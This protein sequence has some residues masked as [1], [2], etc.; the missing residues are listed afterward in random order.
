MDLLRLGRA[1]QTL[2]SD[3]RLEMFSRIC[4]GRATWKTISKLPTPSLNLAILRH[5]G[6]VE[7]VVGIVTTWRLTE[8]GHRVE[9]V[10]A[11]IEEDNT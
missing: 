2:H 3:S 9:R 6:L 1:L 8:F 5:V 4:I 10:L 7:D 11:L